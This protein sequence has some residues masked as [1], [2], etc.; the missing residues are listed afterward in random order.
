MLRRFALS[1]V[2]GVVTLL[3]FAAAAEPLDVPIRG[4]C[5]DGQ[6]ADYSSSTVAGLKA[7]GDGFLAVRTGPGANFR[8][9]DELHNGD[10]VYVLAVKGD[11]FGVL[12]G[13]G[14]DSYCHGSVRIPAARA[15][16]G[17]VHRRWL[18]DLAG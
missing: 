17:W 12:Y 18:R 14:A 4:F 10:V 8:K 3:P 11:W 1:A 7:G 2:A 15:P 5:G 13:S 16:Q 9:I 6:A